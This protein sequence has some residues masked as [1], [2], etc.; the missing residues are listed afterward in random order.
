MNTNAFYYKD[1]NINKTYNFG[2]SLDFTEMQELIEDKR[3]YKRYL[4]YEAIYANT[5]NL[6]ETN[7]E[8]NPTQ[9]IENK[10]TDM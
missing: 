7:T 2:N 9:K 4:P 6:E 3:E 1:E 5:E 8:L 10:S